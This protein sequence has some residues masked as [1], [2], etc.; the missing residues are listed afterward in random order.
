[1]FQRFKK[2]SINSCQ[3]NRDESVSPW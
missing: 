3:M 2:F 1:M